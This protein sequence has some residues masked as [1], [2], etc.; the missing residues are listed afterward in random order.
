MRRQKKSIS[1]GDDDDECDDTARDASSEEMGDAEIALSGVAVFDHDGR[2][3]S[4]I[5]LYIPLVVCMEG[6]GWCPYSC[7]GNRSSADRPPQNRSKRSP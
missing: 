6:V 2:Y 7:W 4:S 1:Q 5:S 3:W